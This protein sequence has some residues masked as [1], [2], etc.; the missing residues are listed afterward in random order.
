MRKAVAVL[1]VVAGLAC[2][3]TAFAQIQGISA[4]LNLTGA[5]RSSPVSKSKMPRQPTP[6]GNGTFELSLNP[7]WY[8]FSGFTKVGGQP[9]TGGACVLN[10]TS[11]PVAVIWSRGKL[12]SINYC[13]V[14]SQAC[15]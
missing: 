11:S 12:F 2:C 4:N 3:S 10:V 5:H 1:S 15:Q 6:P 9:C 8:S 13:K 7:G 14:Q